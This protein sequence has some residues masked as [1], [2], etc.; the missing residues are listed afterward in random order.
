MIHFSRLDTELSIIFYLAFLGSS[1]RVDMIW[2]AAHRLSIQ[3][4]RIPDNNRR[5]KR[6]LN[7]H[8][9]SYIDKA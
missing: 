7:V 8:M 6:R 9:I 5:E 4:L 2:S 3:A 1:T